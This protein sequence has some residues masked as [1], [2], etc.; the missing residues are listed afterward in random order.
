LKESKRQEKVIKWAEKQPWIWIVKYPAGI[1]GRTGTPDLILCVM[2]KFVAIE[3]KTPETDL[4]PMQEY[5]R[6]KI[7]KSGGICKCCRELDEVIALCES[8]RD[9]ELEIL[10]RLQDEERLSDIRRSESPVYV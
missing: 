6:D 8:V 10:R 7:L 4:E 9:Q 2:G 1:F 3:M 5:Q